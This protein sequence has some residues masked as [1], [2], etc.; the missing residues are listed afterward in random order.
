[1]KIGEPARSGGMPLVPSAISKTVRL[2]LFALIGWFG[3]VSKA[4]PT[5]RAVSLVAIL[6]LAAFT[7]L[8]WYQI[9]VRTNGGR[10]E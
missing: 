2:L 3:F 10:E 7:G 4:D 9:R 8:V 6:A 5:S 1:M